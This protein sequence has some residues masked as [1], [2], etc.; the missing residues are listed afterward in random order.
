MNGTSDDDTRF[1]QITRGLI[2]FAAA[3]TEFYRHLE[4]ERIAAW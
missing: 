1:T 3:K 4:G 2:K